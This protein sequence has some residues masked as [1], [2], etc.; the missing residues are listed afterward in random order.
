MSEQSSSAVKQALLTIRKL[1]ARL[2][3]EQRARN[4]PIAIVGMGCRL[5]GGAAG[6]DDF[7]H[8]LDE[9]VDAVTEVPRDRWQGGTVPWGGFL[10]GVDTF[11]AAFFGIAPRE[12]KAMDPQQRLLLEVAWEALERAG[13]PP[14]QL[15]GTST[16]VFLGVVVNDYDKVSTGER[17]IYTVTGNG[18]SFPAGRLSYVLGLEG[19]SM[20]VDTACSSSLV[21][22]HLACQSLRA[23]ES[24]MALAGGVSLMLDPDMTDMMARARALSPDG[25]CKTFDARANGYVRGEGCGVLVL[26][27]LSDALADRDQVLAV[28]RGGAV[29]SD[30]RSSGLTAPNVSAQKALLRQALRNAEADGADIGYVETHGTGTPLGDPIE[31]D[32]LA[33]VYGAPRSDGSRCVLGAVKTNIGHLEAAAGVTAV[34]KTV[35]AM[36]HERIPGNLHLRTL[37]PRIDLTATALTLPDAPVPWPRQE[38]RPRMAGVS[39]FGISGTNAHLVLAQAP[40]TA[41]GDSAVVPGGPA[42]V[43]VSARDP[44]ALDELVDAYRVLL[45]ERR[46]DLDDLAY[47]AAVRRPHHAHRA[48]FVV[49]GQ[50]AP[51][52]ITGTAAARPKVVFVFPGQGSQWLGMGRELYEHEPVFR[53]TVDACDEAVRAEAG[54]SLTGELHADPATTRLDRI[55]VVQP[56]LF[57]IQ[58]GLAAL[59]RS[60]GVEPDAVVGHSMGEV[61]AAQVSGALTPAD[62][63]RIIC[64]RSRLLRRLSGRGAMML[65]ELPLEQARRV[66]SPFAERVSVAAANSAR[67]TVLS[68]DPETLEK[69]LTELSE[70]GVFCRRIKVEVAS[71]SPQVDVLTD[72]LLRELDGLAPSATTVRMHSTVLGRSCDGAELDST[73]WVRNLR[74]PVLFS[75]AVRELMTTG[76]TL[77]VEMSPHPVLLPSI[78]ED[79][80]TAFPSSR[81]E[82]GERSVFLQ[83]LAGLYVRGCPVTWTALHPEGGRCTELPAYPWQRERYWVDAAPETRSTGGHPLL[84]E[85]VSPASSPGTRIRERKLNLPF[86][87]DHKV[88]GSVILPATA[89]VE[90]ALGSSDSPSVLED[91]SFSHM[92][93]LEQDGSGCVQLVEEADRFEVFARPASDQPWTRCAHGSVRLPAP[94]TAAPA[95]E[96]PQK[97][98]QRCPTPVTAA[99]HY[100]RYARHSMDY[101]PAFRGVAEM[102]TGDGEGLG[103]VSLPVSAGPY[104]CHP[105]LLDACFQVLGSLMGTQG[106]QVP[107][108][109]VSMRRLRI[110]HR[111]GEQVWVHARLDSSGSADAGSLL[112]LDDEGEVLI[113]VD[114]LTVRRLTPAPRYAD[115]LYEL[116][117][118]ALERPAVTAAGRTSPGPWLVLADRSGVGAALAA[119][120]GQRGEECVVVGAQEIDHAD[121]EA[122]S[123]LL[124]RALGDASTCAGVVHLWSLDT[125]AAQ[126]TT[127]ETLLEDQQLAGFSPL[128]LVRALARRRWRDHPRL[129]LVTAGAQEVDGGPVEV[130]QAPLW[131]LARTLAMEHPELNCTRVDLDPEWERGEAARGLLPEL[132][133]PDGEDEIALRSGG[134]HAARLVRTSIGAAPP[135]ATMGEGTYLITGGLGGLGLGLAEWLTERGARHVVLMGRHAPGPEAERG[136]DRIR[137]TGAEV[138]VATADVTSRDELAGVLADIDARM[139]PLRGVVHAAM[140][141]DDRSV[142]QMSAEK[143]ARVLAPKVQGAWNLHALTEDRDLDFFLLYSS[144]AVL[145]GSPGQANYTAANAFL[146][147]LARHRR[148][149]GAPAL[150]VDWGLFSRAGVMAT[151]DADNRR[152]GH[153]GV[154]MLTPDEGTEVLGRLLPGTTGQLAA[155]KLNLRQW[156]EFYPAAAGA[157]IFAEL[158]DEECVTSPEN[159][160]GPDFTDRLRAA[161]PQ[162][163]RRLIEEMITAQ[164]GHILHLDSGRID[165]SAPFTGMG[166]DSLMAL[167]LRNR[168][169]SALGARLSVTV[170]FAA[171]TVAALSEQL[172]DK[173]GMREAAAPGGGD[174]L[175]GLGTDELLALIDGA[176]DRIE[177]GERQ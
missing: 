2:D 17:D 156:L 21:A 3:A 158:R 59:W 167:E 141:L 69:L 115:W 71:H 46:K 23:R 124:D 34:I 68:G 70:A 132:T 88:D 154:G 120:L 119:E 104:V 48:A 66:V 60:K 105:A 111:P 89:Y 93:V 90:M 149:L 150:C 25:R 103:R 52:L 55:D 118:R 95:G 163:R 162:Q 177:G 73:Y 50:A 57:A 32:A 79:E 14:D 137:A 160:A 136:I 42:L 12:A 20:V 30:G 61:A 29:N 107:V 101:G 117:W 81:R 6:P 74:A 131:G 18:H 153:R 130:S 51:R 112:V 13:Q 165:P 92:A 63:A 28:I 98:R 116:E 106:P 35:L 96:P 78:E 139:P 147:A 4:E 7:W 31:V 54:W 169:E 49:D 76:N 47:T 36:Q 16:G 65:V 24:A 170:L 83:S 142:L 99:E 134:R 72:E 58:R 22:I 80:G 11:D 166:V 157:S 26:K 122:W 67:S 82:H 87:A 9:G 53:Q 152:L 37:N 174:G 38:D 143:Y 5:P 110:H 140:V 43:P 123:H 151:R 145:L 75:Q 1:Q 125:T 159:S 127:A 94:P 33:E 45:D 171:P 108:V 144:A 135:Q 121:D 97:I 85:P 44:A 102:W 100:E 56:L 155:V 129:W 164:L 109:P 8:V 15:V 39:S 41:P 173:L 176:I 133:A 175:D 40:P 128:A 146:G 86:L 64:R 91:V 27:R 126:H 138:V 10:S 62:A 84:G 19:P 77:F 172:L 161:N 168:L 114:G 113:E 148:A